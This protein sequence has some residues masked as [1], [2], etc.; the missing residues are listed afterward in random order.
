MVNSKNIPKYL[1]EN[2]KFC[3]WKY[4]TRDGNLTKVPYNP[5]TMNKASV[6][7][8][9]TFTDFSSVINALNN[10]DGIGIRVDGKIIA[11]DLDHCI[12]EGKICSWAEEIVSHFQDTYIEISPSGK[13][14][15]IILLAPDNYS[16]DK[17]KYYIKKNNVEVYVAGATNRFVTL[18]GNAI[19]K[20]DVVGNIDGFQWLIDTYMKRPL[21]NSIK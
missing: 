7:N 17:D 13:G 21:S 9:N 5:H 8:L 1:K 4:E 18:T 20:T 10:F 12:E 3:N 2:A 15:R 11:I 6:N 19:Q 14:L 16:Y